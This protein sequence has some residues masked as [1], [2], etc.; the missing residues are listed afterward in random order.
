V[1]AASWFEEVADMKRA[2]A[3]DS[4][5]PTHKNKKHRRTNV[6][7]AQEIAW[8]PRAGVEKADSPR[9]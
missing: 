2:L 1:D 9:M 4:G 8:L 5:L 7:D 3:I 6:S